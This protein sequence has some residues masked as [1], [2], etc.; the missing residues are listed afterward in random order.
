[1]LLREA[2]NISN[3]DWLRIALVVGFNVLFFTV[4]FE[5]LR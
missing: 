2:G 1:M 5:M 3:G 4:T